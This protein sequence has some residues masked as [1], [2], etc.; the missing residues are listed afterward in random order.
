MGAAVGVGGFEGEVTGAISG[1]GDL[2][3]DVSTHEG[4]GL[5]GGDFID[6]W[7]GRKVLLKYGL[8]KGV[9]GGSWLCKDYNCHGGT[10][11]EQQGKVA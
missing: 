9:R 3:R 8:L 2:K 4:L 6:D 11:K 7:N 1:L 10:H 5:G